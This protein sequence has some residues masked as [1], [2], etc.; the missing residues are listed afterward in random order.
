M[1]TDRQKRLLS[2]AQQAAFK[3]DDWLDGDC[4]M[5]AIHGINAAIKDDDVITAREGL[6]RLDTSC[7][8]AFGDCRDD[9]PAVE[10]YCKD[11]SQ[12]RKRFDCTDMEPLPVSLSEAIG[13]KD[14]A[15][16]ESMEASAARGEA[17]RIL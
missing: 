17:V 16:V 13:N 12:C 6:C 15:R 10:R 11:V 7:W 4:I 14:T 2:I 3:A 8:Y 5:D 9:R 1:V